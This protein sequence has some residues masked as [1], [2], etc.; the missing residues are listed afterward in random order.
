VPVENEG[1]PEV[2]VVGCKANDCRA[3]QQNPAT[4]TLPLHEGRLRDVRDHGIQVGGDLIRRQRL[5][6]LADAI[7]DVEE[8]QFT[9]IRAPCRKARSAARRSR[10]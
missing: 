8:E 3:A 6:G 9:A 1:G 7:F 10:M 5:N 4:I 2:L